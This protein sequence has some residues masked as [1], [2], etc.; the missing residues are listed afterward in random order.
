[1]PDAKKYLRLKE[2]ASELMGMVDSYSGD[3]GDSGDK[4]ESEPE[5]YQGEAGDPV[6]SLMCPPEEEGENGKSKDS[7]NYTNASGG[8]SKGMS[9]EKKARQMAM[10]V[11]KLK[12]KMGKQY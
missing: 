3:M 1:M 12:I 6:K 7:S 10:A 9:Q 8:D 11:S 5:D 2:I 4:K